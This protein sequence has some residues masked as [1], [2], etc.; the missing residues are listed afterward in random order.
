MTKPFF[1]PANPGASCSKINLKNLKFI[2]LFIHHPIGLSHPSPLSH[3]RRRRRQQTRDWLAHLPLA[4]QFSPPRTG[5]VIPVIARAA[6]RPNPT[7]AQKTLDLKIP[8]FENIQ[9]FAKHRTIGSVYHPVE[10]NPSLKSVHIALE[11]LLPI[12]FLS[13]NK[14]RLY[15]YST[16][17]GSDRFRTAVVVRCL[18]T[19]VTVPLLPLN[20]L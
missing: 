2:Y 16:A 1:S 8:G 19:T 13:Q 18:A 12:I 9:P 11:T 6:R 3:H 4:W 5:P 20:Y 14:L 17:T 15:F 10:G 7:D